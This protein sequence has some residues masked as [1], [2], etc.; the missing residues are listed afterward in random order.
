MSS[1]N[2]DRVLIFDT[3]LRDGEQSPGATMNLSEKIRMAEQ[4]ELLGTDIIEAGFAAASPGDAH[5]IAAIAGALSRPVICS[6]ARA[7]V[8]DIDKAAQALLKAKKARIHIFLATSPL[9]MEHK[10]NKSPDQVLRMIEEGVRHARQCVADVEFSCEDAS[11]SDLDFMVEACRVAASQGA[12]TINIPDTVGYAQPEEF[13]A[14]ISYLKERLDPAVIISVHC[15]NDLGL[16]AANTLAALK[17]GARQAE[18]TVGGIGERAGNAALEEVVMALTVR[19]NYYK[20]EHN[21]NTRLI[22]PS[23]RRLSRIIGQ[24]IP[25]DKA[26]VGANA[27]AHESGIH[28]A[29]VLKNPETYEIMSPDSIGLPGNA[30]I[31]GKHSGKNAVKAKLENMG[32]S[33]DPDQVDQVT[34]AVKRLADLKKEIYDEDLEAVVLEEIYRIPDKYAL[35]HLG[36]QAAD[37]GLPP[38]AIL[39]L[40]IDGERRQ[41]AGF[42]VGPVDAVFQTIDSMTGR[43]PKLEQYAVNAITGGTDAQGEV[44]VRISEKGKTA[45]GRGAHPDVINASARA[46]LNALNRLAKMSE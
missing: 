4:L 35:V 12:Q 10:L 43:Q 19:R 22:Y 11:R 13:A 42:G 17:A 7:A 15:H 20:L 27:F 14:R 26:I 38:T 46:Y 45:V 3:T 33:L 2:P 5:A 32:Y 44:T 40:D 30:I 25:R 37:T 21:I 16:A 39:V 36:V 6:L 23:V 34:A 28:Q 18:V 24:P 9:H 41:R 31:V 1:I 8:S 29:G